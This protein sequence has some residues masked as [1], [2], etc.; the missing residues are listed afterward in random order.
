MKD[1]VSKNDLILFFENKLGKRLLEGFVFFEDTGINGIDAE[2]LMH[3]FGEVYNVN[4]KNF[5]KEYYFSSESNL[6]NLPKRIYSFWCF[7]TE[8]KSFDLDH[9]M[10]VIERGEWFDPE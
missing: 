3:N 1:R 5:S 6:M 10:N 4:M 8:S 2:T 7:K 9:C